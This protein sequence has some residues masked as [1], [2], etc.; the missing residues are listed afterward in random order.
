MRCY[1]LKYVIASCY[2][3]YGLHVVMQQMY[4]PTNK[5][6]KYKMYSSKRPP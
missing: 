2:A 1:Y 4:Y 3:R 6:T 5:Y